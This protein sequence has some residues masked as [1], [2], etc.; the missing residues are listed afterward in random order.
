MEEVNVNEERRT[1][2]PGNPLVVPGILIGLAGLVALYA[3]K[4]GN[5]ASATDSPTAPGAPSR[6]AMVER[7]RYLVMVGGC[8]DCHTPLKLT[9][10]GPAPDMD[11]HLAGHPAQFAMGPAP[12]FDGGWMWAGAGTNTA[13]NGPWG[14]TFAANLTPDKET[15]LGNWTEQTFIAMMRTGKQWGQPAGRSLQPPM[16]WPNYSRMTDDDLKSIF[17]Y[18]QSLPPMKNRVPDYQ[19]PAPAK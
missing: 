1:M 12:K 7:G 6:Q 15:G 9:E 4:N 11:R 13:F 8:A 10:K 18:L 3:W 5:I 16:P 19:P 2:S 17:A 14:T